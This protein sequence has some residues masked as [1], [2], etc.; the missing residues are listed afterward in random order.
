MGIFPQVRGCHNS[1]RPEA[2]RE[3]H[4]HFRSDYT[5]VGLASHAP[6]DGGMAHS[7]YTKRDSLYIGYALGRYI[8]ESLVDRLSRG[9]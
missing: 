7:P 9:G 3:R 1:F 8:A 4:E 2:W 6:A 5:G